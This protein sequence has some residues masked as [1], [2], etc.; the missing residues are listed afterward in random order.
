MWRKVLLG[1]IVFLLSLWPLD[2]VSAAELFYDS[3]S[4]VSRVDTVNTT[5]DVDTIAGCVALPRQSLSSAIDVRAQGWE[6]AVAT[7]NGIEVYTFDD[8]T[9]RKI[10]NNSLSIPEEI[11]STG[12]VCRDD[13]PAIWSLTPTSLKLYTYIDGKMQT[14]PS[15]TITGLSGAISLS[16]WEELGRAVILLKTPDNQG[17]I[18]VYREAGGIVSLYLAMDTGLSNPV[19]VSAVPGTPDFLYATRTA[20]YY[21][22]YDDAAGGFLL[23]PVKQI[24]NLSGIR[25]VSAKDE[26]AF[27]A[28]EGNDANYYLWNE[29]SGA[30]RVNLYSRTGLPDLVSVSMKPGKDEYATLTAGGQQEYWMFDAAAGGMTKNDVLSGY[31]INLNLRYQSPAEYRSVAVP[32]TVNY[33]TIRISAETDVPDYT[34]ITFYVSTDGGISWMEASNGLWTP[35]SAGNSFAVKA[36]LVTSD[37]GKTP[38]ILSLKLEASVLEVK[39][40]KVL[41][42]AANYPD[43]EMPCID[44]PVRVR[45]GAMVQFEVQSSG[46]AESAW[47]SFSLGEVTCLVPLFSSVEE[48]ETNIWRGSFVVPED[49]VEGTVMEV[50]V[51]VEKDGKQRSLQEE[52]FIWVQGNVLDIIALILTG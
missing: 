49:V 51:T 47:A 21:Y 6:D 1:L 18:E 48:R 12:A 10:K 39:E 31:G 16:A 29:L 44:F 20:V 17:R 37:P 7:A 45:S 41:A 11:S 34:D 46:F 52:T 35:V 24:T 42:V 23:H 26:N 2:D 32:T 8:A 33:D 50:A 38:R 22:M 43:Q 14:S 5:A 25:S 15:R 30:S 9:G 28:A 4:D 19:A 13:V 36:V 40:L 3:F 27:L